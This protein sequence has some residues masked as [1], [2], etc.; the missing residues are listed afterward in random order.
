MHRPVSWSTAVFW[1]IYCRATACR[2]SERKWHFG[3]C[4]ST[5]TTT[6]SPC[7]KNWA[8]E[9]RC[10]CAASRDLAHLRTGAGPNRSCPAAEDLP[11]SARRETSNHRCVGRRC[12][13]TL[14]DRYWLITL[15]ARKL[16][17]GAANSVIFV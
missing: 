1:G 11:S 13:G 5:C 15:V 4:R 9:D 16:G 12:R 6:I 17:A 14:L 8:G 10:R 7:A 2:F 3:C